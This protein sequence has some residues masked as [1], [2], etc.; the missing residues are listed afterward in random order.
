MFHIL[1][2]MLSLQLVSA[3]NQTQTPGIS[4]AEGMAG[5]M[6]P[7]S[8]MILLTA[9]IRIIQLYQRRRQNRARASRQSSVIRDDGSAFDDQ[10]PAQ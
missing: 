7:A 2:L 5:G 8:L 9:L 10:L 1:I 4:L 3:F 6:I